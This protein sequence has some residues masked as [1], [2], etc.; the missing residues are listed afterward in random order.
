MM[1][2][3]WVKLTSFGREYCFVFGI[4]TNTPAPVASEMLPISFVCVPFFQVRKSQFRVFINIQK[5][6]DEGTM[7]NVSEAKFDRIE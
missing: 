7:Q 2:V 4:R 6:Q 1:A 5:V 3:N